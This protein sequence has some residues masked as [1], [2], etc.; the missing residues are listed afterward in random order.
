MKK[1]ERL[2][3]MKLW[4]LLMQERTKERDQR[5]QDQSEDKSSKGTEREKKQ[6]FKIAP[7]AKGAWENENGTK[8]MR[9]SWGTDLVLN[10]RDMSVTQKGS[11]RQAQEIQAERAIHHE[12]VKEHQSRK[13]ILTVDSTTHWL[14]HSPLNLLPRPVVI[15]F[16]YK[17]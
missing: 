14:L 2:R 16:Q 1:V 3:P 9:R 12:C 10:G 13:C 4:V 7:Q 15:H 17:A 6:G 8:W 5:T 11:Q